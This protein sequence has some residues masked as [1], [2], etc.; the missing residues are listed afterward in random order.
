MEQFYNVLIFHERDSVTGRGVMGH[1]MSHGHSAPTAETPV[2]GNGANWKHQAPLSSASLQTTRTSGSH[3]RS[4]RLCGAEITGRRRNG[5]CSDRCRMRTTRQKQSES[6][7]GEFPL[8]LTVVE[9]ADLL[10][11]STKAVYAMVARGQLPG[12]I[13]IG[14]NLRFRRDTLLD[15]IDQKDAPSPKEFGR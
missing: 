10:R 15:W 2:K 13:R 6:T 12:V 14:R 1:D 11:M 5:F 4:C 9:V 7:D 8:L 3:A